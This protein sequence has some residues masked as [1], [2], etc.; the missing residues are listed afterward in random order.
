MFLETKW[1]RKGEPQLLDGNPYNNHVLT[2]RN[3][4][5]SP[6][7]SKAIADECSAKSLTQ[8]STSLESLN[9]NLK[10]RQGSSLTQLNDYVLFTY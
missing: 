5:R 7:S 10:R 2:D 4:Y 9:T 6:Y 1:L 8:T 3:P